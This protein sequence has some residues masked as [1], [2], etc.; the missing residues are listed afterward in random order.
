M[1][2][3]MRKKKIIKTA[4]TIAL[5]FA[6]SICGVV[7]L[8]SPQ[9]I[10]AFTTSD[11]TFSDDLT[12]EDFEYLSNLERT[13]RIENSNATAEEVLSFLE[14]EIGNLRTSKG[15]FVPMM[16]T[17]SSSGTYTIFG[18]TLTSEEILL[19]VTYPS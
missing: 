3:E 7:L 12:W 2:S 19:F 9:K 16:S 14:D 18:V 8:N 13:F 10:M 5:L 1:K 4:K 6:I 11:S 17:S 15:N